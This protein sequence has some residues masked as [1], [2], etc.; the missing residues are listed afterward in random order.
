MKK[1]LNPFIYFSGGTT[2]CVGLAAMAAMVLLAGFTDQTFRG[3]LS[4]GV[5]ERPFWRL[6]LHLAGGWMIFSL[7]LYGAARAFS[8]SRIR[9]VD[10]AGNQALAK[11]PGLLMLTFGAIFMKEMMAE[12]EQLM[13]AGQS[14]M[15]ADIP[16]VN[17]LVVGVAGIVAIV[18]FF[19]WSWNGFSIAANMRGRRAVGIYI[20]CYIL[21]EVLS[22]FVCQI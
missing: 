10:I 22:G 1:L 21:A 16:S 2:L 3:I 20:V 18:W 12:V 7:L 6:A 9:F 14:E 17:L 4:I 13:H 15:P 5:G 8:P 11:M 19:A